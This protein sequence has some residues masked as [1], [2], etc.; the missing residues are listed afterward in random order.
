MTK[1]YLGP[2]VAAA[3]LFG[4][5]IAH[6]QPVHD[7]FYWIGEMNK[8]SAVMVVDTKIVER[9]LGRK[10][11]AAVAKVIH[12][13]DQPGASRPD[14]YLRVE[15]MLIAAEGPDVTR[16]HSGRSRQDMY[17]T[18]Q[19]LVLRE[20]Y[21][22]S[23][24]S[25]NDYRA[26]LLNL[27]RT[28]PDAIMPAFTMGVQAQPITLGHYISGYLGALERQAQRIKESYARL[29]LS[30]LGAAAVGT[31]SFPIDRSQLAT[32]LGFDG[33]IENSFD[34]NHVSP[35][36]LDVEVTGLATAS[37]ITSGALMAD[38][39][40]Q[41]RQIRP[42]FLLAPS[43]TTPSSI[44]PQKRNPFPMLLARE[45]ATRTLGLAHSAVML[46]HN[47]GP[48]VIE[49]RGDAANN[50]VREATQLQAA[51]ARL[52][53][54]L[55][56]DAS[57]ALEEVNSDYATTTELADV[58]QREADVPFRVGHH[59]A[60]E[61]VN[62]GRDHG[63]HAAELPYQ[64]ARQIF[65]RSTKDLLGQEATFP[66]SEARFREVL[67]PEN[68]VRSSRGLGGPQPAEVVRVL[69]AQEAQLTADKN[70]FEGRGAALA[71]AS[72]E[73]DKAFNHL[74]D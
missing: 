39:L 49:Y 56:F 69:A 74:R 58:L 29:N 68:M 22:E 20:T 48:G 43:E 38:L 54:T 4:A 70:W 42:W 7:V 55:R 16:L 63:L 34:A 72:A 40:D 60:S 14:D 47:I 65:A 62:F 12:D 57:R 25:L 10:I 8:A 41:Y 17:S 5:A 6:A 59:F 50:A 31:S 73:L 45:Q 53:R 32:L 11:A 64:D 51:M 18:W 9:D 1:Q 27:A 24:A 15:P 21:L 52:V 28:A 61:L 13:G 3:T 33:P 26:A 2:V 35:F 19:R 71:K 23:A 66:L 46:A 67:T 36:D 44:M 37:A 30:P